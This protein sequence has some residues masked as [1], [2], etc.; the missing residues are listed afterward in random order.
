MPLFGLIGYPL[1]HSFSKKYFTEKFEKEG[2]KDCRFENFPIPFIEEFPEIIKAYPDLKGIAVTIPYKQ[3]VL[4]YVTDTTNLSEG[5]QACNCIKISNGKLIAFNTDIIGFKKSIQ[6]LLSSHHTKALVLGN[7]GAAAA[8]IA[9][10]RQMNIDVM[11]VSRQLHAGSDCT[12]ADLTPAIIQEHK[13]I[14]NTTP[15]GMHP[16]TDSCP[17]IPYGLLD[18][19]YLLYDL[20]YNPAQT[21]FLKKGE[22][23]GAVVKNGLDMLVL[24]AEENWNIWNS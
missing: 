23:K 10:L 12:Y 13:I 11:V 2:L 24:Q 6:P 4:K 8:V 17:D 20:V 5:L 14:V 21:L 22:E 9:G 19:S 1:G 3:S 16:N 15:L 7:G 18:K